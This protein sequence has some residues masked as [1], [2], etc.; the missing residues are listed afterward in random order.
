M[1][2][3]SLIAFLNTLM[4]LSLISWHHALAMSEG[5]IPGSVAAIEAERAAGFAALLSILTFPWLVIA[6]IIQLVV[7]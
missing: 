2:Q 3:L 7:N 4:A 1:I 6:A 5:T